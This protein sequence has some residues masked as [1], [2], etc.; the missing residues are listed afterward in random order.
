MIDQQKQA[1]SHSGA[2]RYVGRHRPAPGTW[3]PSIGRFELP[4]CGSCGFHH[5]DDMACVQ[6]GAFVCWRCEQLNCPGCFDD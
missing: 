5:G 4:A 6:P 2:L 1:E 3:S